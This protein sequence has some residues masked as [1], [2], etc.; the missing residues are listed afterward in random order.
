MPKLTLL[1]LKISL[2]PQY[3]AGEQDHIMNLIK[4]L[5]TASESNTKLATVAIQITEIPL[6]YASQLPLR[7]F[8]ERHW[9]SLDRAIVNLQKTLGKSFK[10]VICH[11][12]FDRV[13]TGECPNT[14]MRA[15]LPLTFAN[16]L[17]HSRFT[18]LDI[19]LVDA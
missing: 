4:I 10:F 13:V 11:G 19:E 17:I 2:R 14:Y 8:P 7:R 9:G 12:P 1:K 16:P 6:F 3:P 15:R 5:D 18:A